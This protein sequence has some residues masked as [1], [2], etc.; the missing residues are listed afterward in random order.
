MGTMQPLLRAYD[1]E[2][3]WETVDEVVMTAV[4]CEMNGG[5]VEA[6]L[7][8]CWGRGAVVVT[9]F[10]GAWGGPPV[11]SSIFAGALTLNESNGVSS[12]RVFF[13]AF[14]VIVLIEDTKQW[15][16]NGRFE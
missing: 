14:F 5:A 15:E 2:E 16:N 6:I 4:A 10:G 12:T 11:T 8:T 1:D 9:I 13:D 3:D 7:F